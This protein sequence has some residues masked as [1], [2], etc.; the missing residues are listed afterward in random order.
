MS[1]IQS[2]QSTTDRHYI[3]RA[4]LSVCINGF[5]TMKMASLSLF[6]LEWDDDGSKKVGLFRMPKILAW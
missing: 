1:L 3:D 5:K 4:G 2:I 6:Y